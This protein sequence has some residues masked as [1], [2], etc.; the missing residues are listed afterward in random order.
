MPKTP[1]DFSKS[2]IYKICCNDTSITDIYIC[3]TTNLKQR[4]NCHKS[5]CNNDNDKE[6]NKRL[7]IFIREHLG[8]E[9]WVMIEIE[10]YTATDSLDLR[11][12]ERY[13]IEEL[14]PTLN[15]ELPSRLTKELVKTEKYVEYRKEWREQHKE[16]TKE[17][18]K[19]FYQENKEKILERNKLWRETQKI[20][21]SNTI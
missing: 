14:K 9:N 18:H 16:H 6:H 20:K 1:I 11:K 8:W 12:R 21:N 10:K 5:R 17:Y 19:K 15:F 13:W 4:K 7:Y 2:I 3:S